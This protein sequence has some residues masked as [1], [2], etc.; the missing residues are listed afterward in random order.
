M[1][2]QPANVPLPQVLPAAMAA[3]CNQAPLPTVSN[4][5]EAP[6]VPVPAPLLA[7]ALALAAAAPAPAKPPP[8]ASVAPGANGAAPVVAQTESDLADA[9]AAFH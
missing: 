5:P 1:A 6:A 7:P 9:Q 3:P 2:S 8:L 4:A